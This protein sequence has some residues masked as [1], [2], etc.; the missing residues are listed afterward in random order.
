MAAP[1]DTTTDYPVID[2]E[3]VPGEASLELKREVLRLWLLIQT[4]P[5]HFASSIGARL[6][7]VEI[8]VVP[9]RED[10]QVMEA[11]IV[12]EIDVL[13][14]MLNQVN[15]THGGC[16]AYLIDLCTSVPAVAL[17]VYHGKDPNPIMVSQSLAI[18][19]LGPSKPGDRLRFVSTTVVVGGRVCT[20]YC[21]ACLS[22]VW[23]KN[24]HRLVATATH[25]KLEPNLSKL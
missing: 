18:Q 21:E 20:I 10:A 17:E 13:P 9:K 15:F 11:R 4:N 24:R 23:A 7:P 6:E 16:I 12:A 5:D 2:P 19:F 14:G 8:S 25:V 3:K 1:E 22:R